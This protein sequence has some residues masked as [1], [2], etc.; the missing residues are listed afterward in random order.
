MQTIRIQNLGPIEDIT[1]ELKGITILVGEQATGKS[2]IAQCVHF[3][4]SLTEDLAAEIFTLHKSS[5]LKLIHDTIVN[6]IRSK[7]YIYYGSSKYLDDFNIEFHYSE[8]RYIRIKKGEKTQVEFSDTFD[9][10]GFCRQIH[11]YFNQTFLSIQQ[12]IDAL[13]NLVDHCLLGLDDEK[14]NRFDRV[15]YYPADRN[16][17]TMYSEQ[18]QQIFLENYR[19]RSRLLG[20]NTP[21]SVHLELTRDFI[22]RSAELKEFF[23]SVGG[24]FEVLMADGQ[25]SRA[26]SK[27]FIARCENILRGKYIIAA[28]GTEKIKIASRKHIELGRA[29]SG[30]QSVVRILQE[31]AL[32]NSRRLYTYRTIEEPEVHL[33][34]SAQ[35]YLTE[36]L[37]MCHNNSQSEFLLTTH[38]P[39]FV[40]SFNNA[41][42]ASK[43]AIIDATEVE[44]IG[45]PPHFQLPLDSFAAYQIKEGRAVSIYFPENALTEIDSLDG[46]SLENSMKFDQLAEI[47]QLNETLTI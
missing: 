18:F 30:Q 35:N 20:Q 40:A 29:S 41:L 43:A 9:I 31:L 5:A 24:N 32:I 13:R 4:R 10:N 36:M 23:D 17:A 38:S 16:I 47:I 21:R 37:I 14:F 45:Y 3:F 26:F 44:N 1:I 46:V 25:L 2:T 12:R 7:F 15:I 22:Q 34:P 8:N 39:Y 19:T 6:A 11:E 28:D 42:Y 27:D 33:F